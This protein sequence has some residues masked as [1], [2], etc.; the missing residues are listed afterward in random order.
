MCDASDIALP[1]NFTV[2][3]PRQT[4]MFANGPDYIIDALRKLNVTANYHTKCLSLDEFR[5]SIFS[6]LIRQKGIW[7]KFL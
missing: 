1:L 2:P 3:D 5:R 7:S 6:L 4:K